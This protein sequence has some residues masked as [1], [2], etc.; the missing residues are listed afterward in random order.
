MYHRLQ[1]LRLRG[2][3]TSKLLGRKGKES[4]RRTTVIHRLGTIC[5]EAILVYA[6]AL[7]PSKPIYLLLVHFRMLLTAQ[8]RECR[9]LS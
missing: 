2:V 8:D 1:L 7:F 9:M 3:K 6:M 5:M 4:R